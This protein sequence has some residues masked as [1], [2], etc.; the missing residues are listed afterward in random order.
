[1]TFK[2]VVYLTMYVGE[3]L[4]KWYIGS[5]TLEKINNGYNGS[6][7]SKKYAE[8]Y[9]EEQ[10]HNKHL[11][12]TRI[13]SFH[14]STQEALDEELRVQKLHEVVA[15][16]KY[17]N[18]SYC[19]RNGFHGG[20]TSKFIDYSNQEYKHKISEAQRGNKNPNYGKKYTEDDLIKMKFIKCG[21]DN[22][23]TGTHHS[24]ES[25]RKLSIAMKGEKNPNYG[26]VW[27]VESSA[28]NKE[29]KKMFRLEEIPDDW[30]SCSDFDK[31][32][33][34]KTKRRL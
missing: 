15:N 29:H 5:S 32:N 4:P 14:K 6:V 2:N 1:M 17:M 13:L 11:F 8:I 19:Q 28:T 9:K 24:E 20:D 22:H 12:K 27:C 30:I 7:T 21:M 3:K 18:M 26:K 10:K 16:I 31:L 25:R 33:R 23:M 34:K